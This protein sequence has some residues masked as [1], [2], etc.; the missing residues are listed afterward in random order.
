MAFA[1]IDDLT[2][3]QHPM[4]SAR[5]L[6]LRLDD[7]EIARWDVASADPQELLAQLGEH[8]SGIAAPLAPHRGPLPGIESLREVLSGV[9]VAGVVDEAR[10]GA[11]EV[12][13]PSP[14]G[15]QDTGP[16]D[17]DRTDDPDVLEPPTTVP[18]PRPAPRPAAPQRVAEALGGQATDSVVR[19]WAAHYNVP[20]SMTGK[21]NGWARSAYLRVRGGEPDQ[22]MW[23]DAGLPLADPQTSTPATPAA[24]E[25]PSPSDPSPPAGRAAAGPP[26][27]ERA[28]RAPADSSAPASTGEGGAGAGEVTSVDFG[29]DSHA[30]RLDR[31]EELLEQNWTPAAVARQTGLDVAEVRD[32]STARRRRR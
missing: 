17:D 24:A 32:L 9:R 7:R 26:A 18:A 1:L 12:R 23:R 30:Q 5:S 6:S 2:G 16:G 21:L 4:E 19:A 14:A 3:D 29:G 31:A 13:R 28:V 11:T 20:C 10:A 25:T 8:L 22:Q 27:P 15:G